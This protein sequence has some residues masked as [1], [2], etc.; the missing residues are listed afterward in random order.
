MHESGK[1]HEFSIW[2]NMRHLWSAGPGESG[3][4]VVTIQ[5]GQDDSLHLSATSKSHRLHWRVGP[6]QGK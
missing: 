4:R 1:A 6:S 3:V 2:H 5:E